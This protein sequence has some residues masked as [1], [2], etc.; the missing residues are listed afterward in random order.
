MKQNNT[1]VLHSRYILSFSL[2]LSL[3]LKKRSVRASPKAPSPA[4]LQSVTA[5]DTR[6]QGENNIERI[7]NQREKYQLP[8]LFSFYHGAVLKR[9]ETAGIFCGSLSR[10]HMLFPL[11]IRAPLRNEP[12]V[13][14]RWGITME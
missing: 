11:L 7:G 13:V 3:W 2:S 9:G 6:R 10:R 14:W 8:S 4:P 1:V 5:S 12:S